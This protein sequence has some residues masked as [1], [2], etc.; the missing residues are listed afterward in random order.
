MCKTC[1]TITALM[2]IVILGMA[3]KFIV[4]GSVEPATDGRLSLQLEPA[5]K[6][7]GDGGDARFSGDCAADQ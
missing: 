5:R 1:W 4:V 3:Y 2:L 6:G 7:S